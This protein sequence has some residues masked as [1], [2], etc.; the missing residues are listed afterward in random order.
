[1]I[2]ELSL[3][4]HNYTAFTLKRN[5]S[6]CFFFFFF[7]DQQPLS[8][9]CVLSTLLWVSW[10]TNTPWRRLRNPL[11]QQHTASIK[12]T[13]LN[14]HFSMRGRPDVLLSRFKPWK[15]P[16]M[17]DYAKANTF[18]RWVRTTWRWSNWMYCT[19]GQVGHI[20]LAPGSASLAN[21]Q[22]FITLFPGWGLHQILMDLHNMLSN[23]M[24][25]TGF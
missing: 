10:I 22:R 17:L 6:H 24:N 18:K 1:M 15:M 21:Q 11:G 12:V 23:H 19:K 25:S 2:Y 16:P 14:P 5:R 9:T 20:L 7:L 8:S 3:Q 4:L 13:G